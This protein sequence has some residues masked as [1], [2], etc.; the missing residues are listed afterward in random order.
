MKAIERVLSIATMGLWVGYFFLPTRTWGV[1]VFGW[2]FAVGLWTVL[3]P[4]GVLGWA[5]TARPEIDPEDDR[6]WWVPR[7]I[8]IAFIAFSIAAVAMMLAG[9]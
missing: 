6:F 3:Y 5:K 9:R 4:Q 1:A 2:F 8:G 7:F